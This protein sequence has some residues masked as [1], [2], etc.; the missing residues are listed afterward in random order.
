MGTLDAP[1]MMRGGHG[2]IM[3]NHHAHPSFLYMEIYI[4]SLPELLYICMCMVI[5][6]TLCTKQHCACRK[7]PTA[8]VQ[9]QEPMDEDETKKIY[10]HEPGGNKDQS[11][12]RKE[13]SEGA[14]KKIGFENKGMGR[15]SGVVVE[16]FG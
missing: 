10:I 2:P 1:D 8:P 16:F 12:Q 14:N 15:R 9:K 4:D 5:A 11:A 6:S 3:S 13:T 7:F